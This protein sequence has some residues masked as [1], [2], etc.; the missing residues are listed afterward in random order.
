[1]TRQEVKVE[2]LRRCYAV[3]QMSSIVAHLNDCVTTVWT[4]ERC[5][6]G[7]AALSTLFEASFYIDGESYRFDTDPISHRIHLDIL[8][9]DGEKPRCCAEINRY[10]DGR[11]RSCEK[12]LPVMVDYVVGCGVGY[13]RQQR[14]L[15]RQA[16]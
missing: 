13:R 7:L 12:L 14:R 4:R 3:A 5:G 2:L 16:A 10:W 15:A 1:M 9:D 11:M 6:A 8:L